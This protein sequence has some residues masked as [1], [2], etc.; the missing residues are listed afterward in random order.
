MVVKP[1]AR[2]MWRTGGRRSESI[3]RSVDILEGI[4]WEGLDGDVECMRCRSRRGVVIVACLCGGLLQKWIYLSR[5]K[6]NSLR[7]IQSAISDAVG[8]EHLITTHATM[9]SI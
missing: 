7:G 3:R 4:E 5:Q 1:A 8:S 9:R 6:F 2:R